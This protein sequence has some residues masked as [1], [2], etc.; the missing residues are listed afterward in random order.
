MPTKSMGVDELTLAGELRLQITRL[1]RQLRLRTA[2]GLTPSQASMIAAL[3]AG[4]GLHLG[5]LA[6]IEGV[7]PPTGTRTVDR[8]VELGLVVRTADVADARRLTVSL[9]ELGRDTARRNNDAAITVLSQ[10]LSERS[11]SERAALQSALPGL[12]AL[13]GDLNAKS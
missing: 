5:E 7:A 11:D 8:L 4:D 9:T 6:K 10:A 3:N 2:N 1:N 12:Q 13:V